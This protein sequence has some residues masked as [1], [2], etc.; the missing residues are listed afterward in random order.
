MD[1]TKTAASTAKEQEI[2]KSATG[3]RV[4][5]AWSECTTLAGR[6]G[7]GVKSLWAKIH[8]DRSPAAMLAALNEN[9]EGNHKRLGETKPELDRIYREIVAKKKD[10]QA[11][12]PVRQRLLKIELQTL[13]ARYKGLEREFSILCENERSIEMV[14]GRF[15]EVL[16]YG[17]RGKLNTDMVDSL[18]DTVDDKAD[19]AEDIRDALDGLERAGKRKDRSSDD[20]DSEIAGF[21]GELNLTETD[22]HSS[23]QESNNEST[24]INDGLRNGDAVTNVECGIA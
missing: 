19:E 21:D 2:V 3:D 12:A 16:A 5:R 4:K 23:Q 24:E 7:G 11:A 20:F 9:L 1:E 15:L 8:P 13:M 18:A 17:M 10:Y 22:K 6:L 14:K